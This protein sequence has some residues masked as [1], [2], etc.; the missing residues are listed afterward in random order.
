M[1]DPV[2]NME[3][4]PGSKFRSM[5]KG[6]EYLFCSD[7]CKKQFDRTPENYLGGKKGAR[8]GCC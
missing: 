1:I 3:V 5:Q 4:A 8:C 6:K 7:S 2:C